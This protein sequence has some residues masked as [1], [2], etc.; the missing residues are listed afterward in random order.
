MEK[1]GAIVLMLVGL[2]LWLSI[3]RAI[4]DWNLQVPYLMVPFAM[5]LLI[6][7]T[8]AQR[9]F[10]QI[11]DRTRHPSR[12]TRRL[13]ALAAILV[14]AAYLTFTAFRQHRYLKPIWP[15]EF[16]F[17]IQMRMLCHGRLW[18][19]ANEL[20]PF[21]DALQLIVEPV[22]AS[23]YSPGPS[24]LYWPGLALGW[25]T[26]VLPIIAAALCVGLLYLIIS[27]LMDGLSGLFAALMLVSIG[28]F[29]TLSVMVMAQIPALLL[30]LALVW[31]LLQW[32]KSRRLGWAIAIGVLAG[33]AAITRPADA[34][35]YIVP[36]ALAMLLDL[37]RMDSRRAVGTCFVILI[38]AAP[39]VALQLTVNKGITGRWLTTPWEHYVDQ[40]LPGLRLG[41]HPFDQTARPTSTVP[42]IQQIFDQQ[43]VPM[44]KAHQT[45]PL[46]FVWW[47]WRLPR[48]V[49]SAL[50]QR[51]LLCIAPV[52]LLAL[53]ARRWILVL[54]LPVFVAF[55]ALYAVFLDHYSILIAPALILL[56][57]LGI[58]VLRRNW[59][60]TP[61]LTIAPSLA[62]I[63]LCLTSLPEASRR[64]HDQFS[65]PRSLMALDEQLQTIEGTAL[66]LCRYDPANVLAEEVVYNTSTLRPEDGRIVLAHDRGELN[67]PIFK[68][69]ARSD[70]NRVVYL[71]D[72]AE[73][74]FTRLGTAAELSAAYR[75]SGP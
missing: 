34:I 46:A 73:M 65:K 1:V 61:A 14:A 37:K 62:L 69:Y 7:I 20:A 59:P 29:R 33:W 51:M 30:G 71:F 52:G 17:V 23:M 36:V 40:H 26:W 19:P 3:G 11:L 28:V 35:C 41:F 74:S 67:D 25:P 47:N 32:R 48:L 9:A 4:K 42:Q 58:E 39:F 6:F 21:F 38:A 57:L 50:P 22:Y 12:R 16:S 72:R 2:G 54:V 49:E 24:L 64:M 15:D 44:I 5:G 27:E 31:T 18:A 55:Y 60:T 8:P 75:G 53:G 45:K 13:I 63:A 68:H 56:T 10:A 43:Y 66:I 70:P